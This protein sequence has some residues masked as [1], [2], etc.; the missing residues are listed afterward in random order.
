MTNKEINEAVA[1]KLIPRTEFHPDHSCN[2]CYKPY[3]TSIESAWE[4]MEKV[5]TISLVPTDKGWH[6]STY[7]GTVKEGDCIELWY[8]TACM[9]RGECGCTLCAIADTAPMA[10]C[11]AFL[12]LP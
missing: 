11:L 3:C 4:I 8:P 5:K 1:I 6:A 10:I 9:T 2:E 12:K 7:E